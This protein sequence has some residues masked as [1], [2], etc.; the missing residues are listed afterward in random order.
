MEQ[1]GIYYFFEHLDEGGTIKHKLKL[2][3]AMSA[4]SEYGD[5]GTLKYRGTLAAEDETGSIL[6]W[7]RLKQVQPGAYKVNDFDFKRPKTS[8]LGGGT[9]QLRLRD[10]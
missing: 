6:S 8:L 4:H 9:K 7:S 10:L 2:V 5:Y 1:E 3:D